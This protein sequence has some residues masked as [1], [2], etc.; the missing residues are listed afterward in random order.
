MAAAMA[1]CN[2]SG[3]SASRFK[4]APACL[5]LRSRSKAPF[6]VIG[7]TQ[8]CIVK[9]CC[10]QKRRRHTSARCSA[11]EAATTE[12]WVT[13]TG[14]PIFQRMMAK[15]I[16]LQDATVMGAQAL[17][18]TAAAAIIGRA[19]LSYLDGKV[20]DARTRAG[21]PGSAAGTVG[22]SSGGV[23]ARAGWALV[24]SLLQQ[25]RRL[26][27]WW[28][29]A[30]SA[31]V[32]LSLAQVALHHNSQMLPGLL[33]RKSAAA[34]LAVLGHLTQFLQDA[35]EEVVVLL[36]AFTLQSFKDKLVAHALDRLAAA[37]D[38]TT[39]DAAGLVSAGGTLASLVIWSG[40]ALVTLANY[41]VNLRPLLAS[42]GASSIVAG[43]AAQSLLRNV[44]AGVTLYAT[45]PFAVGDRV[46]FYTVGDG[47]LVCQGTVA[48]LHPTRTVLAG[49]PEPEATAEEAG[50]F[51]VNNGDIVESM[52]VHNRSR[53]PQ[54]K[55]G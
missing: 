31:T 32:V 18:V 25:A 51:F 35:A 24:S 27:P 2:A 17:L 22:A 12:A 38:G 40:A 53:T 7:A 30:F 45:R 46:A 49:E 47:S 54:V 19:L 20:N 9:P 41:G 5:W 4:A 37:D 3:T 21:S 52:V 26:L 1:A 33:G 16:T 50:T 13:A 14:V 48:A 23:L 10:P 8:R 43:L 55:S 11:A 39:S 28:C 15:G 36:C 44:A 6:E 29:A 34:A 42:L